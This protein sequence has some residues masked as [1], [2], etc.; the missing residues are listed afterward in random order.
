MYGTRLSCGL[1][2]LIAFCCFGCADGG[3]ATPRAELVLSQRGHG[4]PCI[5]AADDT[6]RDEC[7]L[8]VEG[9]ELV[10]DAYNTGDGSLYV[11]GRDT[12]DASQEGWSAIL[13]RDHAG[14]PLAGPLSLSE[15][16]SKR[17]TTSCVLPP[18]ALV[19]FT[20][21]VTPSAHDDSWLIPVQMVSE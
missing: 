14:Q 21:T 19:S 4:I 8:V 20:L 12:E 17:A 7:S 3:E 2:L 6:A 10:F 5:Y 15:A 9:E 11:T 1:T 16:Q 18:C 13:A